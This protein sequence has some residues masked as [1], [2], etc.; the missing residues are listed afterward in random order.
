MDEV[1]HSALKPLK[2]VLHHH[3]LWL[4]PSFWKE[5]VKTL[6]ISYFDTCV[7]LLKCT[8]V[9]YKPEEEA[10]ANVWGTPSWHSSVLLLRLPQNMRIL[11]T[12]PR[13]ASYRLPTSDYD[14]HTLLR[15]WIKHTP[16]LEGGVLRLGRSKLELIAILKAL[17]ARRPPSC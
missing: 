13:K 16:R 11:L 12:C 9:V 5:L 15:L 10:C 3:V 7:R 17:E 2:S 1:F 8:A 14:P 6:H 4:E